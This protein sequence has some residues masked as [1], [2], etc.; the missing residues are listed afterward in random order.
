MKPRARAAA[1]T[2]FVLALAVASVGALRGQH[3]GTHAPKERQADDH[4]LPVVE[5]SDR[6]DEKDLKRQVKGRRYNGGGVQKKSWEGARFGS[7]LFSDWEV[8]LSA[9]PAESSDAVI[10]GTVQDARAHLSPDKTGVYSEFGVKVD[11]VLKD[12]T[13][14][15]SVGGL[16]AADR[17]G[18]RVRYPSGEVAPYTINA[19]GMPR[20]NKQYVLFLKGGEDGFRIVTGYELRGGKAHALDFVA[21]FEKFNGTDEATLLR[22]IREAIAS[23]GSGVPEPGR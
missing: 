11:E 2:A 19:Q 4:P 14:L 13:N 17:E 8:G 23:P 22:L 1:L 9:L 5:Y 18:G 6:D 10:V 12:S 15:I 7:T 3:Q 21:K 16:V 20:V